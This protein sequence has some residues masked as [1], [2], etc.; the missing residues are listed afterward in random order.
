M[1]GILVSV[2]FGGSSSAVHNDLMPWILARGPDSLQTHKLQISTT[3]SQQYFELTFTSSVLHLRG[4]EVTTQPLISRAGD[5]L[6]WNGEVWQGLEIHDEENDGLRL[7][8]ALASGED[9]WK[10]MERIE[11]PWAMVYFSSK[12]RKLWFGRDC[13]GRRSLLRKFC[14]QSGE[15][16]FSSAGIDMSGWDEVG[17]DGL[18]CLD[19]N[20]WV[21]KKNELSHPSWTNWKQCPVKLSP[22]IFE[23]DNDEILHADAHMVQSSLYEF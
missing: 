3:T 10:V 8:E 13:L 19:F 2:V 7:L 5:V 9:V 16:V 18:W 22:W 17:V 15:L 12:D 11:G 6:C 14:P 1:C 23:N 21:V 20:E 4:Q